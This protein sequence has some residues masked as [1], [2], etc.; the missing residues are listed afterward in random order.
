[1]Y[2]LDTNICSYLL[3]GAYPALEKHFTAHKLSDF[4]ISAVTIFELEY[5]VEKRGWGDS[6]RK[7][8]A[9]FLSPFQILDFTTSDAVIAADIRAFLENQGSP[10]GPYDLLIAAQGLSRD[11]TVITHNFS[12]FPRVPNL[13]VEDWVIPESQH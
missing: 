3:K 7:K 2:I 11:F 5:G 1:M 4:V 8:L 9:T 13:K 12:E 6:M 10:I